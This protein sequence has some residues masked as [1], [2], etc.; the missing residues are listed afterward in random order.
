MSVTADVVK[1]N[2][3]LQPVYHDFSILAPSWLW[4][5]LPLLL[6]LLA[7]FLMAVSGARPLRV[8][9]VPAWRSATAGV[10]G[11][12]QYTAF[13]YATPTRKMV[14][15]VLFTRAGLYQL[16]RQPEPVDE[17]EALAIRLSR[18]L[19]HAYA[20]RFCR[21]AGAGDHHDVT[22]RDTGANVW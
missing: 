1:G 21:P 12:D 10:E 19:P 13:G 16:E 20:D 3:V 11:A 9:R 2:W 15:N 8:R 4:I 17:G 5:E 7:L 14:A 6:L 22:P 18:R